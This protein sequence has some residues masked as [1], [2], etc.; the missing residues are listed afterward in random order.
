[1]L[2]TLLTDWARAR[3]HAVFP[4][5]NFDDGTIVV[6]PATNDEFGDFQ[7][8]AAMGLAKV[9]K[10]KPR[11]IAEAFVSAD[12][13]HPAI[14]TLSIAGP[15]FINITLHDAWL[16][17]RLEALQGDTRRGVPEI[18]KGKTVIMD[19]G[20]PNISKPL[21]IG[22]LRSH[23]I[24]G[25]LDRLH[26]FLG[27]N[28]IADNH[29]GDWGAQFG[30]T[31]HGYRTF[32]EPAAMGTRP[33]AELERVYVESFKRAE[34]DPAWK[35][36]CQQETVKLQQGDP[37]NLK[38]W[39]QFINWSLAELEVTY[40]RLGIHYDIV[41]GESHYRHLLAGVVETLLQKGLIHESNGA[42]VAELEEFAPH[43]CIVRKSDGGFNYATT[44]IATVMER[45]REFNPDRIVYVT[46]ARQQLHF[47]QFFA[48]CRRMGYTVVLQHIWF[49]L[50][51]LPEGTFSTRKGNAIP[52]ERL[53]DEAENR[54][55]AL[56]RESSPDMPEAQQEEVAR[57]V[58][59]GAI[60]YTD[61][62]QNPQSDITFTWERALALD[63]NSAPYLQYA[64]ARI[65]S[66]MDR[67]HE[68]FPTSSLDSHAI[69]ISEPIERTLVLKLLAFPEAVVQAGT[70]Y[71]PNVLTDY[72]YELAQIYSSFH[73]NVPFLK[74]EAGV[75]ESRIKLCRHVADALKAGL[76][77][78]GIEAPDRI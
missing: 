47:Q 26:R 36:A 75:R 43:V 16:L 54:A 29:L 17:V 64:H 25:T 52:L 13:P 7:C 41:H 15:G 10:R 30:L 11:D 22:H 68:Q 18:G 14:K 63:G 35:E 49:G 48:I 61:L 9:L 46:D 74:A 44:D 62:S 58:G 45:V 6:L 53:L 71:R 40:R 70:S 12:L 38:L 57:Q 20:S 1:M 50:I 2:T 34:N 78:L 56:V 21:H 69:T 37:D 59:I 31:I 27:F 77:L 51:R 72:L 4:N 23:N 55:L 67:Y 66:V 28:V 19:Y 8:N 3:F 73:Q 33:L 60:K 24:G 42:L 65:A 39:E 76:S 5:E 32:G